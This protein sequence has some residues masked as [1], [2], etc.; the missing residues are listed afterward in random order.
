[1][2]GKIINFAILF[3]GLFFFL[4]KPLMAMLNQRTET[5]AKTL[6]EAQAGRLAAEARLAEARAKVA[7]LEAELLRLRSEA[8]EEGRREKDRIRE[9][10]GKEADRLRALA[11]L[12]VE[13]LL[14]SG[15]RDLKAYTAE[16]AAS[17]AEARI[18]ARLTE[19]DQA[20]LIDKSI[21]KLKDLHEES[22]PR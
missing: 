4:R 10:A 2:I 16:L 17:L 14:K 13:A 15:V 22:D 6:D 20:A 3:G 21:A 19:A 5:I 18:K 11:R 7:A 12:E 1:V 8:E 9:M